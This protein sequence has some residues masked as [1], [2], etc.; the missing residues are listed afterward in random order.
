[1]RREIHGFSRQW[2]CFDAEIGAWAR[3]EGPQP[4]DIARLSLSPNVKFTVAFE[5]FQ[6]LAQQ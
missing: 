2:D 6:G 3:I 4:F 1:V 5:H